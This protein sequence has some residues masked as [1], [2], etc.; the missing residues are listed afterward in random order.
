MKKSLLSLAALLSMAFAGLTSCGNIDDSVYPER[1]P[2]ITPSPD[3]AYYVNFAEQA[4]YP[5]YRLTPPETASYDVIDGKLVINNTVEQENMWSV[6]PF[7]IDWFNI[8]EGYDYTVRIT[9]KSTVAGDAWLNFGTWSGSLAKY[10]FP[11]EETNVYKTVD[12][13]FEKVTIS[14]SGNDAHV[15]FQ[16]GKLVGT[17]TIKMVEIFEAAPAM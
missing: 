9:Y 10:G 13:K 7:I 15:L 5:Y 11:I 12:V 1:E 4:S 17:V 2:V 14:T 6:Q 16:M 3:A 8:K